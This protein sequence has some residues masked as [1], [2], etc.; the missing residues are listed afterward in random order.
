VDEKDA[1]QWFAIAPPT[2]A[3]NVISMK[4]KAA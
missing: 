3:G 2:P 4:G 1:R